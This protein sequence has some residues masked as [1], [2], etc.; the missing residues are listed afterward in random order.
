MIEGD[1]GGIQ[2]DDPSVTVDQL[3]HVGGLGHLHL[4]LHIEPG[5]NQ[6]AL[7]SASLSTI[8]SQVLLKNL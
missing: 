3:V 6:L 4:S 1:L 5:Y 2:E 8:L 7:F